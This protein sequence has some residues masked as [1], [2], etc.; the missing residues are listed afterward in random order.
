VAISEVDSRNGALRPSPAQDSIEVTPSELRK[1]VT[2]LTE[3]D[4]QSFYQAETQERV[5]DQPFD[6]QYFKVVL[7]GRDEDTGGHGRAL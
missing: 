4:K 6:V 2:N 5:Y 1:F 3:Q 7:T